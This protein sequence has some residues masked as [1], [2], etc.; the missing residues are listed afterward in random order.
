MTAFVFE[1]TGGAEAPTDRLYCKKKRRDKSLTK[2]LGNKKGH[3]NEARPKNHTR[4]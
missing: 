2:E 3:K 1:K 4:V